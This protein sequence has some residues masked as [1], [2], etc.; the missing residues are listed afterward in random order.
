MVD[1]EPF[2]RTRPDGQVARWLLGGPRDPRLPFFIEDKTPV[3]I[4]VP[5][6]NEAAH[7]NGAEGIRA[8]STARAVAAALEDGVL[9]LDLPKMAEQQPRK[10]AVG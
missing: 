5:R 3:A 4:R 1:A 6:V 7:P 10:I 8:L 2:E 9:T